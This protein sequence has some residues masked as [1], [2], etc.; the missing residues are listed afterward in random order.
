MLFARLVRL[1]HAPQSQP[2]RRA[3][4]LPRRH[5]ARRNRR[6]RRRARPDPS[7]PAAGASRPRPVRRERIRGAE[8]AELPELR[9]VYTSVDDN[10]HRSTMEA[11][12]R[13]VSRLARPVGSE[14]ILA[15][16]LFTDIVDSTARA[17]RWVTGV[18]ASCSKITISSSAAARAL[19]G[20]RDRY[21]RRRVPRDLR[22]SGP[23]DALCAG[24]D[25]SEPR[26][27]ARFSEPGCIPANASAA[28]TTSAG[29]PSTSAHASPRSPLGEVLVS[30]TVKDLV[31]GSG[32]DFEDRGSLPSRA[33]PT[34][35]SCSPPDLALLDSSG[36]TRPNPRLVQPAALPAPGRT[37]TSTPDGW[38]WERTT[39]CVAGL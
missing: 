31:A 17:R 3:H 7:H 23:S 39:R 11:T 37:Y 32:L 26:D 29:S 27:R 15:T 9:G 1:A 22:R 13:F 14:R 6:P 33:S 24:G 30:R 21:D 25:R 34:T 2:G 36:P 38:V 20:P 10:A 16:I 4:V 12:Q 18:G 28:T 5:G 35:G 8:I 19:R